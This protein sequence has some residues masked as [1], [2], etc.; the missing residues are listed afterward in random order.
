MNTRTPLA[1]QP[2]M[3]DLTIG[4]QGQTFGQLKADVVEYRARFNAALLRS[5]G[6]PDD[7]MDGYMA[8]VD[9][10]KAA[11]TQVGLSYQAP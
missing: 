3:D 9:L 4:P 10:L 1:E 7:L 8:A 2:A 5:E 6:V 11:Y